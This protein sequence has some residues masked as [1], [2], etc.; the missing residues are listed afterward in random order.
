MFSLFK[1]KDTVDFSFLGTDLHSHLIAGI[2]DGAKTLDE[3]VLLIKQLIDLGYSKIVT[4]PHIHS[5]Y[6]PNTPAIIKNGLKELRERLSKEKLQIEIEAAAEYFIDDHFKALIKS[7]EDL[8]SFSDKHVLMECSMLGEPPDLFHVI[9]NLKTKGYKPILA[10]PERYLYYG[11]RF[12]VFEKIKN[13]GCML[14]VNLLSLAGH[15][16]PGQKKLGIKLLEAGLVDYLGT[17]LHRESHITKI[18]SVMHNRKVKKLILE[19]SFCNNR[20]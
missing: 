9:F 18:E 17:D 15:Y 14:Q 7:D 19:K 20:L 13:Q 16:G 10:H 12:E 2:D 11:N 6:Y 5:E 4:T 1:K 3:S 8:L